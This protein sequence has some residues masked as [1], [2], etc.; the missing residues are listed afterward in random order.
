MKR[1]NFSSGVARRWRRAAAALALVLSVGCSPTYNWREVPVGDSLVALLPC[2]PDRAERE[3]PLGEL[4][5]TIDMAGCEAAGVLFTVARLPGGDATQATARMAA[6]QQASRARWT[7]M[8]AAPTPWAL[9][10]AAPAP[11]PSA[12]V[13]PAAGALPEA[14]LRWFA[15]ADARGQYVLYQTMVLG[16]P[17][18]G[19]SATFFEGL[20]LR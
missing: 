3:L 6:W 13:L 18:A 20:R 16:R 7:H 15:A 14:Q 9:P 17:A 1:G 5:V 8:Q 11:A 2:K 12:L 19:E 10:L 4:S